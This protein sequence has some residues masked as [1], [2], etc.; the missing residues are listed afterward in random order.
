MLLARRTALVISS[1]VTPLLLSWAVPACSSSTTPSANDANDAGVNQDASDSGL[2]APPEITRTESDPAL[3]EK[4]G[5]CE[6][7]AGAWPAET[8]GKELPVGKDIPINHVIVIMQENRSFDNYLGR[9]VAQGYYKAGDFSEGGTGFSNHDQVDV[10]GDDWFNLDANGQKVFPHP[11]DLYC[12]DVNHSWNDMHDD[13]NHGKNDH[14]VLNNEPNGHRSFFYEDDTVIPFYYALADRFSMG[15]RYFASVMTSTWT[16]RLYM[17]AATSFGLGSNSMVESDT[18]EAPAKQ[19]FSQ[20]VA[21][22]HT[23]KDYA[24]GPHQQMF[25]PTFGFDSET[26]THFGNVKCDL[27][28]DIRNGTLP[29]V[30]YVMGT[31]VGA[32]TS[33]EGPHALPGIGGR[34]VEGLIRELF[35]SPLWKETAV[36]ITYDENGGMADHVPPVP[37]CKPDELLPHDGKGNPLEGDFEHTGFRVPF[38]VVSPYARKH[39]VSHQIY[40]HTSV[41]RFIEARFGLPAMSNRDANATPPFELFDFEN[42]PYMTPPEITATTSVP[43]EVLSLCQ[44]TYAPLGCDLLGCH[45]HCFEHQEQRDGG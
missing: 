6:Y 14:F 23:W 40:D 37:A 7:K 22:G 9:L 18:A 32:E 10:P 29:D 25:F 34:L 2:L 11:D 4:R 35:K 31:Q 39:F 28:T 3:A 44:Q 45:Q 38:M 42:P 27:L 1:M 24:D 33:D 36:F 19:I 5:A 8:L 30:A 21:G 43:E 17:M 16:N 20:L 15:D 12:Y 41:L 13:W 26:L